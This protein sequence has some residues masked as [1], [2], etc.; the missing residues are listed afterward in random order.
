MT[1][2]EFKKICN[3]Y[4]GKF[5]NDEWGFHFENINL[6]TSFYDTG[7]I[8]KQKKVLCTVTLNNKGFV[9]V[10]EKT[11]EILGG[12]SRCDVTETVLVEMLKDYNFQLKEKSIFDLL[13]ENK[14]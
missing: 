13:E 10:Y 6:I 12:R 8:C 2:N 9:D 5:G 11:Y 7:K 4:V 1:E 14:I 3:R